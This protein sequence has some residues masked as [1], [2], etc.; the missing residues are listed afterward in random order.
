MS[1]ALAL[2]IIRLAGRY[3]I[4]AALQLLQNLRSAA[5]ID[6]AIK[7]L[8]RASTMTADDYL[9]AAKG[10]GGTAK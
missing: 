4:P 1:E 7:A 6:D 8:E 3:G 2:E 10:N 9:A 5:T